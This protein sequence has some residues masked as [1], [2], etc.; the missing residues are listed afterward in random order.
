M[1]KL[2]LCLLQNAEE[3]C[4]QCTPAGWP[5]SL[6]HH[7]SSQRHCCLSQ[8]WGQ[9][10]HFSASC[11][12]L[13]VKKM[14]TLKTTFEQRFQQ[15]FLYWHSSTSRQ[16]LQTTELYNCNCIPSCDT[17]DTELGFLVLETP[18]LPKVLTFKPGLGWSRLEY[19]CV[20]FACCQEL[21]LS[22]FWLPESFNFFF[23]IL[24]KHVICIVNSE[25]GFYV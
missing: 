4:R 15:N 12:Y 7:R 21:R 24:F 5:S 2:S 10:S 8:V 22:H 1:K 3:R 17:A 25:T 16:F 9:C 18:E 20:C 13:F 6:H 19:S 11:V 23:F 14:F